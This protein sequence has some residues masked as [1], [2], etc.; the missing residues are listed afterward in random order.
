[1]SGRAR[2][3]AKMSKIRSRAKSFRFRGQE[4]LAITAPRIRAS[5]GFRDW[6]RVR[7]FQVKQ[8]L[9]WIRQ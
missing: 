6:M 7:V 2:A 9:G 3:R 1:M 8:K 4:T 5:G